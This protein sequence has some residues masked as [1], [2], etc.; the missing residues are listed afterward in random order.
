M[1]VP[2]HKVWVAILHLG[3]CYA[4]GRLSSDD[5]S[6]DRTEST[7]VHPV[8]SWHSLGGGTRCQN[9]QLVWGRQGRRGTVVLMNWKP[10]RTHHEKMTQNKFVAIS[11][12]G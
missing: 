10:K 6:R 8:A 3:A 2:F 9:H 1:C 7:A 4:L 11:C 12:H 5:A